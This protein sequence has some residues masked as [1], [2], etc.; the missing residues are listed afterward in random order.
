MTS[1]EFTHKD[2]KRRK[3]A[4]YWFAVGQHYAIPGSEDLGQ[5]FAEFATGQAIAYYI[6]QSVTFLACI[7]DQ[8]QQFLL[9]RSEKS[10]TLPA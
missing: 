2:V 7:P 8:W 1:N 5:D 6:E 10:A 4:A 9:T 3:D